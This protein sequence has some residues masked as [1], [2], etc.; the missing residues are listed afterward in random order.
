MY[1][2][3]MSY[4][5][6]NNFFIIDE[7]Y[8]YIYNNKYTYNIKKINNIVYIFIKN[9]KIESIKI[10]IIYKNSYCIYIYNNFVNVIKIGDLTKLKYDV[11]N[12]LDIEDKIDINYY[13]ENNNLLKNMSNY[14]DDFIKYH[15]HYCGKYN[16]DIYFKY[17]LKKYED[18]IFRLKYPL[19]TYSKN[20]KKFSKNFQKKILKLK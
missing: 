12:N 7:Y 10:K 6:N 5:K 17:L 18:Y 13:I 9:N 2:L 19:L 3:Y 1:S 4:I 11:E 14:N 20:H 16:P 8:I 15:W